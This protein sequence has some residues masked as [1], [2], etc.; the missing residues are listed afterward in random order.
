MS[1]LALAVWGAAL[2]AAAYPTWEIW[3]H[4]LFPGPL[5]DGFC[6]GQAFGDGPVFYLPS[7]PALRGDLYVVSDLALT[8]AVPVL[9]LYALLWW[10]LTRR[11]RWSG[12]RAA[13][14]HVVRAHDEARLR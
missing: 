14:D 3:R 2:C 9:I 11:A 13:V 5:W 7:L 6:I 12:G 4:V 10:W 1:R 8:W